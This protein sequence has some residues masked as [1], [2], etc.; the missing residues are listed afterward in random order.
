MSQQN[1]WAEFARRLRQQSQK[2]GAPK[3]PKGIPAGM[4]GLIVLGAVGIAAVS[5]L[6]NGMCD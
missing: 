4:G 5:S 2:A 3:V 6:Y 1:P